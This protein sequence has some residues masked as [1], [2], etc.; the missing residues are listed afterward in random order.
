MACTMNNCNNLRKQI[1]N[2]VQSLPLE[3]VGEEPKNPQEGN[4]KARRCCPYD[5]DGRICRTVGDRL[6]CGYNKNIGK[7]QSNDD[8]IRFNGC[9]LRGGRLECG[10]RDILWTHGPYTNPRRP[11]PYDAAGQSEP[12]IAPV[13]D[14]DS[15]P[16]DINKIDSN[17]G[18]KERLALFE[19]NTKQPNGVTKC[20]EIDKRIVCKPK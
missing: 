3:L 7:P 8:E 16:I 10:Y 14:D 20:I 12:V 15:E 11:L 4:K 9:R 17:R 1:E 6:L 18:S 2:P 5:F 19:N 13:D